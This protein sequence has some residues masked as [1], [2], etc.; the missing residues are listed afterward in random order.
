[1]LWY[2]TDAQPL[3]KTSKKCKGAAK[4]GKKTDAE[5]VIEFFIESNQAQIR[6]QQ[7]QFERK[8]SLTNDMINALKDMKKCKLITT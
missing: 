7:E 8:C 4:K 1:M 5:I 2:F 3:A 6:F